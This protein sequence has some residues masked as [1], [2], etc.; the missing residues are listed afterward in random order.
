MISIRGKKQ[1]WRLFLEICD[2]QDSE[3]RLKLLGISSKSSDKS[4]RLLIEA[5]IEKTITNVRRSKSSNEEMN[6]R[7]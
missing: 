5:L 2:C 3:G 7:Y 1:F 6:Q 4:L